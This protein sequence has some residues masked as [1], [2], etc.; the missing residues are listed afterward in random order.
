MP[1][2]ETVLILSILLLAGMLAASLGKRA[3]LPYTVLLVLLGLLAA[4][5]AH[6]LPQAGVLTHF[7]LTP[8]VVLF[9][10]LPAL[11]F[12]SA[13]NLDARQ[14][15]KDLIPVLALAVPALLFSALLIGIGLSQALELGFLTALLFGA[16]ISATDPV[17]VVALF[18]ELGAPARLTVLV[19]GE[20]LFNDATAIVLFNILLALLLKGGAAP[21]DFLLAGL[22][23]L[24]VFL[25]GAL[26]GALLGLIGSELLGRL[27]LEAA[28]SALLSLALAYG[29]F[30][31]AE[32]LLH[33]SG[34]VAVLATGLCLGYLGAVRLPPVVADGLGEFWETVALLCNTLLFLLVGLSVDVEALLG[35]LPLVEVATTTTVVARA[36]ALYGMVPLTTRLFRL[37]PIPMGYQ[38]I[39]WWGGLK[40]G[41]AIAM[42]LT[43][44][45]TLPW[46]DQILALTVGVVLATLLLNGSTVH[47]LIRW[48]GLDR[49][50]PEEEL[51]VA[52]ALQRL[53]QQNEELL[54]RFDSAS[55]LDP[56]IF[57]RLRQRL[58]PLFEP[59]STTAEGLNEVQVRLGAI[60]VEFATLE[61][62]HAIGLI[63]TYT[64]LD[65][66]L[67]L[68]AD[69]ARW[70]GGQQAPQG[71]NP[72][73]RLEEWLIRRLRERDWAAGLLSRLQSARLRQRMYHTCAGILMAEAAIGRLE[74]QCRK[75]PEICNRVLAEY[76][77]R[78]QRRRERL[79][80]VREEFP[81]FYRMFER[82]LFEQ[83]LLVAARVQLQR[84]RQHGEI[85][86]KAA[87]VV[88]H[89]IEEALGALPPPPTALRRIRPEELIRKVPLFSGLCAEELSHL[90]ARASQIAYLPG[91]TIIA[92]GERGDA[93]YI[94]TRGRVKV[95]AADD[96]RELTTLD[97][98][99][100]FGEAA[101]LG[102]QRRTATVQAA[103]PATLLR[104]TRAE[105]LQLAREVPA[106]DRL[107]KEEDARRRGQPGT[108]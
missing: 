12:E 85:G 73:R 89:R 60:R 59:P 6:Q 105:V 23:F 61:R 36:A 67:I 29:G 48:L 94:I 44:P 27:K 25:G 107:L 103:T 52:H 49:I 56:E 62:L 80:A 104:L 17:A 71:E 40:G 14:L 63:P 82:R 88:G 22:E 42:A 20:S 64:Y 84:D 57:E 72:F 32:H 65:L 75:A 81:A 21:S 5:V 108:G 41:L 9:L 70:S 102:D 54:G 8:E 93:L 19:E 69:R 74:A 100:F 78:L 86:A 43:L 31:T 92:A 18:R 3:P 1:L 55:L 26:F 34:V 68:Q 90:A 97:E 101:L 83:S 16:L 96:G 45:E 33:V 47:L 50:T 66:R 35:N 46:R 98:G 79:D 10:L 58:E 28:G 30:V 13:F 38:H 37:P 53:R 91:D 76:R 2:A 95:L 4:Q 15:M 11:I 77:E 106:I 24:R 99:E 51:E 7:Q 87:A 39:M